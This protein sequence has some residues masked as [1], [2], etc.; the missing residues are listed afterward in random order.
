MTDAGKIAKILTFSCFPHKILFVL[1]PILALGVCLVL[2]MT[3]GTKRIM[4]LS[5]NSPTGQ[6]LDLR[7]S[8]GLN[9][10]V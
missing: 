4:I 1:G 10:A 7:A 5:K 9:P 6:G 8:Y 3:R 2:N